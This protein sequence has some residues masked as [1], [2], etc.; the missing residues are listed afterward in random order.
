MAED[1]QL[2]IFDTDDEWH[3]VRLASDPS[4]PLGFVPV[5]YTQIVDEHGTIDVIEEVPGQPLPAPGTGSY[6]DPEEMV[7]E[8]KKRV[9]SRKADGIETWT[10][11]V[12]SPPTLGLY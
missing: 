3:L 11:S 2:D 6:K 12:S 1:D 8:Q 7:R 9:E 4:S 10:I 5:N